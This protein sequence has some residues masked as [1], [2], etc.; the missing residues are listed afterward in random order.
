M[1]AMRDF[2]VATNELS[3]ILGLDGDPELAEA[4]EERAREAFGRLMTETEG[5]PV[6]R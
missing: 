4:A 2:A 5:R 6:L 3:T 1:S